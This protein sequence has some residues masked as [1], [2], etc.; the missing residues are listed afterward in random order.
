M[1]TEKQENNVF[2]VLRKNDFQHRS[3]FSARLSHL[4]K[5]KTPKYLSF[6]RFETVRSPHE[7]IRQES[8]RHRVPGYTQKRT[9]GISRKTEEQQAQRAGHSATSEWRTGLFKKKKKQNN[10]KPPLFECTKRRFQM[11]E[12][13]GMIY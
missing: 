12:S 11:S 10:G 4:K 13:L 9:Q 3:S 6:G 8:I 5:P 2:K 1:K 7:G